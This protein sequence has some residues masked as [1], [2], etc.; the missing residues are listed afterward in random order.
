MGAHN[1]G[2][3]CVDVIIP[4]TCEA[5]R[6]NSL[7]RAISS[8]KSQEGVFVSVI[9][10]VNGERFSPAL[11]EMLSAR[12]DINVVYQMEGSLPLALR[13]GRSLVT[14]PFFSFLDDDDVYLVDALKCRLGPL[15]DN[16]DLGFVATNGYRCSDGVDCSLVSNAAVIN[17]D[18]MRALL[19]SNWL[20]SCGG[21]Y[22]SSV[23]P[24]SYFDGCVAY[25]E[26]TY[27]AYSL[28]C[29][30]KMQF[31]DTPTFRIFDT[32]GSLSKHRAYRLSTVNALNS[33]TRLDLPKY[34]RNALKI[35]IGGEWHDLSEMMRMENN[36]SQAWYFH[37]L[38]LKSPRGWRFL[39][40]SRKLLFSMFFEK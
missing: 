1:S 12:D 29:D 27:L 8:V 26:W 13:L 32:P 39:F 31:L 20:A 9:V 28:S 18:P 35:K 30:L 25:L 24:L 5:S 22:R 40:Y 2:K 14:A 16:N 19:D 17:S 37:W 23:V 7:L 21:L 3:V 10:V 38:S 36:L 33:I 11:F 15:L 4:T 6:E 34:I